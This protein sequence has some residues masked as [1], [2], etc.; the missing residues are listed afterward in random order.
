[1]SAMVDPFLK[2]WRANEY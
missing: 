1:M 2:K